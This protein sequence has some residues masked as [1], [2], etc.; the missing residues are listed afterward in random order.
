MRRLL[1]ILLWLCVPTLW[2]QSGWTDFVDTYTRLYSADEAE[3]LEALLTEWEEAH[4]SPMNINT[5]TREQLLRLPFMDEASVDSLLA[6]RTK[7]RAFT[8]LSELL[9]IYRIGYD[10]RRFLPL[11]LTCSPLPKTPPALREM[12]WQGKFALD[13]RVDIPLYARAGESEH[14]PFERRYLGSRLRHDLRL[15]YAHTNRLSYGITLE[16]DPYEP[17]GARIATPLGVRNNF[18]YDFFS[19]HLAYRSLRGQQFIVGDYRLRSGQG[20]LFGTTAFGTK[21]HWL[22]Q[23]PRAIILRPYRSRGEADYYRGIATQLLLPWQRPHEQLSLTAFASLKS[24]DARTIGDTLLTFYT[25]G[26]HRNIAE[27]SHRR[28]ASVWTAG[29][30]LSWSA[31]KA[32]LGVSGYYAHYSHVVAPVLRPYNRYYLRGQTA[33]GMALDGYA[34]LSREWLWQGE[35]ALDAQL[36]YALSHTLRYT[37]SNSNDAFQIYAQHRS[38]S[39]R[40]VAPFGYTLMQNSRV[41]NEHG[42]LLATI[43]SPFAKMRVTAYIDGSY[44]PEARYRSLPQ[45]KVL[46]T[47]AEVRWESNNQRYWLFSHK[48]KTK[49]ETPS[50]LSQMEF[51]TTH[52]FSLQHFLHTTRFSLVPALRTTL[53]HSPTQSARWGYMV[54]LRAGYTPH[55][56][57]RWAGF[58]ALFSS[59]DHTT[60]L[61]AY[62]PQL[63]GITNFPSYNHKGSRLVLQGQWEMRPNLHLSM[64]WGCLKL[65]DQATI[66]TGLQAIA[67]SWQNDFTAQVRWTF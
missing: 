7:H 25:S 32:H 42:I 19:F 13:S 35:V 53:Y 61:F 37:S 31:P 48:M 8:D 17:F 59:D 49:E 34:K 30:N 50:G 52:R 58:L 56:R 10:A 64:R 57:W 47:F 66:G 55:P 6:Y 16:K 24:L 3:A 40:F 22:Q 14:T 4:R 28:T 5:A 9:F 27:L 46:E 29:A 26:L 33:G 12:L 21:S 54:S 1:L 11:F 38:I 41:A 2:A 15:H 65:F 23:S 39:P 45:S 67:S 60:R 63:L 51:R 43:F 20:L 44:H 62:E 36:H 18:P